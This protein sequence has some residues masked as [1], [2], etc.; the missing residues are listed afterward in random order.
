[1]KFKVEKPALYQ[2]VLI[3]VTGVIALSLLCALIGFAYERSSREPKVPET[4]EQFLSEYFSDD[5]RFFEGTN[6]F[7]R[8]F[9]SLEG[10]TPET[11]GEWGVA[12]E[13]EAF[14]DVT[15]SLL[16]GGI[17]AVG[18]YTVTPVSDS[19]CIIRMYYATSGELIAPPVGFWYKLTA[20]GTKIEDYAIARLQPFSRY[21]SEFSEDW[22]DIK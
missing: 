5:F 10:Q 11:V 15:E 22:N 8:Y 4:I 12:P 7:Y 13:E 3:L 18:E 1:M 20:D 19:F 21:D 16:D 14:K 6:A 2:V 17:E 9:K